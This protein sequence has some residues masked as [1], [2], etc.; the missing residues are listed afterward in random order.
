MHKKLIRIIELKEKFMEEKEGVLNNLV[1]QF[2]EINTIIEEIEFECGE[3]QEMLQK[4]VLDGSDF[5]VITSYIKCLSSRKQKKIQE[6][7]DINR[8]IDATRA[9]LLELAIE[10]NIYK[11]LQEKKIRE[12]KII[13]N[14]KFQKKLDDIA[15]RKA[16]LK[17]SDF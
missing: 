8:Q 5:E 10:V 13:E 15:I 14:R 2:T 11:N 12:I 9:E 17:T 1:I 7:E 3:N 16:C 6:R 4:F